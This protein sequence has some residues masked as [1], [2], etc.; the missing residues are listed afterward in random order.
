V[1]REQ[2]NAANYRYYVL[3]A[4]IVAGRRI[5]PRC[6]RELQDLEAVCTPGLLLTLRLADATS[7]RRAAEGVCRSRARHSHAVART[8][9]STEAEVAAFDRRVREGSRTPGSAIIEYAVEPKF[10]GLAVALHYRDGVFRAG[11][12]ARRWR[13]AVRMSRANL[14]T[15]HAIPMRLATDQPAAMAGSAGRGA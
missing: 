14:R 10:D 13:S 2:I 4:P 12:D 5:R 9:P 15:I 1:L 8:T 6:L 7:R 3:D 11:R